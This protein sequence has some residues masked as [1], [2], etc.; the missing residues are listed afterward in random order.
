[1]NRDEAV[2]YIHALGK[3]GS[4]PGLSRIT[5]LCAALGDP[6]NSL[7]FI[8]VAGTNGKGSVCAVLTSILRAGGL[9]VGTYTSPY[10]LRFNERIAVDGQPIGDDELALLIGRVKPHADALDDQITEFELITAA[11]FLYFKQKECD[12]VVLEVGLGGRFDATNVINTSVLSVITGI[13]LDHT[14]ILGNT[15][16][17]IAAEKAGI[18][19][20]GVP[21]LYG[22]VSGGAAKVIE[23]AAAEKGANAV[24]VDFS[25][26]KNVSL[27]ID[28]TRFEIEGFARPFFTPLIGEYQPRN[29]LISIRAAQTLNIEN[30]FIYEGLRNVV[31]KARFEVMRKDPLVIYDGAHNPHGAGAAQRTV[32]TL[33]PTVK[34]V[35]VTGMM[36]DKD[37]REVASLFARICALAVCV[38][39]SNPRS[40]DAEDLAAIYRSQGVEA[41]G[42]DN[43]NEALSFA[44]A[45]AARRGVPIFAAGS[46]YMY[47][48]FNAALDFTFGKC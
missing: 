34:P 32:K 25:A 35:L 44:A 43:M 48:E 16:E 8:H 46:L 18:I 31:W 7:R 21:V 12:V 45:E 3:F 28:G 39:P 47:A 9:R 6:Q 23:S 2:A 29:A 33:F 42:F 41:R 20:S 24:P 4:R 5:S 30:E 36:A 27:S 22:E 38:K 17:K 26:I 40:I 14:A 15:V 11:A 37:C 10:I 13:A 1:M 19:K